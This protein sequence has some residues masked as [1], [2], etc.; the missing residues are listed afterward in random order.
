MINE[1]IKREIP[2]NRVCY[3]EN[4][5]PDFIEA[6]YGMRYKRREGNVRYTGFVSGE[7]P[8]ALAQ[9]MAIIVPRETLREG[10]RRFRNLEEKDA[11]SGED[12]QVRS[13]SVNELGRLE[14]A[15]Q[16]NMKLASSTKTLRLNKISS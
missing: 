14:I 3:F 1:E 4:E 15:I 10:E 12:Y 6:G 9:N 2:L 11:I 5:T 8:E 13:L 16:K 7:S